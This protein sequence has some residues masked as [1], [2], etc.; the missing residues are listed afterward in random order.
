MALEAEHRLADGLAHCRN[1][2][3]EVVMSSI[4]KGVVERYSAPDDSAR[5]AS[6][7]PQTTKVFKALSSETRVQILRL[8][9]S[10]EYTVT[11]LTSNFHVAQPSISR[12]L[13]ILSDAHLVHRRREG[14]RVFYGLRPNELSLS[15]EE[16]FGHFRH[17]REPRFSSSRPRATARVAHLG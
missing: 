12:H 3:A 6:E 7:G 4:R 14:Q 11:E 15:I 16:F 1:A 9:D 17:L 13:S 10:R 8:L 5:F 2:T